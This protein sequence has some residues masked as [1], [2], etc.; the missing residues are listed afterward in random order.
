MNEVNKAIIRGL[1]S[2]CL[3]PQNTGL[4]SSFYSDIVCHAPALGEL[5]KEGHY[6]FLLSVFSGFPG[7][8]WT[9][10]DQVAEA[11]KV[12]TRWT[13]TGRHAGTFMGVSPSGRKVMISGVCIDRIKEGKIVEEWAE[14]DTL[15]TMQQLTAS[16]PELT[17]G[18]LVAP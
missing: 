16:T 13:F 6:E 11:D 1:I 5:H 15:G 14:W 18:D 2:D 8:R 9:I 4:Y 17:V 10:E 12:V 7:G 3:N